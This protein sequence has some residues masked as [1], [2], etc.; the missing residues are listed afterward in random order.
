MYTDFQYSH[1]SVNPNNP[2]S[3]TQIRQTTQ[4][5]KI[6][7]IFEQTLHQRK[8]KNTNGTEAHDKMLN[9]INHYENAN[10]RY[11]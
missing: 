2:K 9:L 10:L 7:K 11:N 4:I 8:K 3:K 1:N 5:S 6:C